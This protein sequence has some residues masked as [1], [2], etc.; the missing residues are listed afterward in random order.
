MSLTV[1]PQLVEA[2]RAGE[3]ADEAFLDCVRTSLPFAYEL[4]ERLAAELGPAR[5][6]GCD[7]TAF[8]GTPPTDAEGGQLL[9]AMASTSIRSALE[10]HFGV[11]LVF[12]NCHRVGMFGLDTVGGEQY[13]QF[14][15]R[16]AQVLNQKPEL[17]NC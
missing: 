15:S 12:Q 16:E 6:A 17:I 1:T 10:R 8:N 13:R 5:A 9:R 2:A 3:L 4:V 11:A 7:F 14:V